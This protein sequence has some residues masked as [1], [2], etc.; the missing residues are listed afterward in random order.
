MM[1]LS[2]GNISQSQDIRD[3]IDAVL[4]SF[5]RFAMT[6]ITGKAATGELPLWHKN[7]FQSV[8]VAYASLFG[9]LCLSNWAISNLNP[10]TSVVLLISWLATTNGARTIQVGIIHSCSHVNCFKNSKVD[11]LL[12]E[13]SSIILVIRAF[14]TYAP[15]HLIHHKIKQHLT[16]DDE[17]VRFLFSWV[18]LRPGWPKSWNK[19]RLIFSMMSPLF[20]LKFFLGRVKACFW[21]PSLIH[22]TFAIVFWLLILTY[23]SANDLWLTFLVGWLFPMTILYQI[24]TTLRLTLEHLFPETSVMQLRDLIFVC[25]ATANIY[26]GE[27]PP[28][29]TGVFWADQLALRTWDI[30]MFFVHFLFER[31][32]ILVADTPN[33]ALHHRFPKS[34]WHNAPY[35]HQIDVEKDLFPYPYPEP[36]IEIW[37]AIQAIDLTLE[38]LAKQ[39]PLEVKDPN[40][41]IY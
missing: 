19:R 28:A 25:R 34:D 40:F 14:I 39:P 20:H 31:L 2:H 27:M 6:E 8:F 35:T 3:C 21:S 36:Y 13:I 38:S 11:F 16:L 12:G 33:H 18:G 32:F 37:G 10:V 7:P 41:S 24:S 23:I 4:P 9:G 5:L 17:T 15:D 1:K 30:K 26:C 29:K 22:N